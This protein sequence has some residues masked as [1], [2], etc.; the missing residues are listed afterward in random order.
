MAFMMRFRGSKG[1]LF[2]SIG[3]LI[4]WAFPGYGELYKWIDEK[5]T[6]HFADDLTKIPERY[7]PDAEMRKEP[8]ESPVPGN[9]GKPSSPSVRSVPQTSESE[10]VE[11][12]LWRKGEIWVAEAILN[13]KVKQDFVVD[14][15]ASFTLINQ[16]TARELN[17][18]LDES[19]PFI[20]IYTA[21][22]SILCPLVTLKSVRVGGAEVENVD[23]LIHNLP[24]NTSGLLGNSFLNKFRVV[25]DANRNKMTLFSMQGEPSTDRPGGYGKDYWMGRFRFYHQNLEELKK[26]K[27][28]H[29]GQGSSSELNRVNN[30]IRYFENQLGELERKASF[31]GVPRSWRE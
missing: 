20:P 9:G 12:D 1:S 23:A 11:V 24:S 27:G 3:I 29:E 18:T 21:S 4:F 22:G 5:G 25:L 28:R 2:I 15:G 19:T 26:L 16:R 13:G 14:T 17:L 31:A 8:K 30:A 7:R 10:G 6:V